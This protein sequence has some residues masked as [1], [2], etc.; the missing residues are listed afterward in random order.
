MIKIIIIRQCYACKKKAKGFEEWDKWDL[1]W[2][3]PPTKGY[4]RLCPDCSKLFSPLLTELL[5]VFDSRLKEIKKSIDTFK[6]FK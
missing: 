1:Y 5:K 4:R 6:Y 3:F 2:I